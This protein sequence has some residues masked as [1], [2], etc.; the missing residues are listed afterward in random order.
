[1]RRMRRYLFVPFGFCLALSS[2][3]F[4]VWAGGENDQDLALEALQHGEALSLSEVLARVEPQLGGE[5]VGVAFRRDHQR[6]VYEFRLVT[7][8]GGIG[9]VLVD[10]KSG[11]IINRA[12][13]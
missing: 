7:P 3:V 9:R 4:P 11:D 6:W 13:R 5:I 10:A 12:A 8:D 2:A 1:M